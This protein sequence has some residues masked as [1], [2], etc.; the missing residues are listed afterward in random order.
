MP[1]QSVSSARRDLAKSLSAF[2]S[3]DEASAESWRWFDEGLGWNKARIIAYGDEPIDEQAKSQIEAWCNRR[4]TGEPWAYILGRAIWRGRP[5]R[6]TPATL[7]P[8]PDTELAF[9]A[10]LRLAGQLGVKRV[11]DVGTGCGILAITLA[12]EAPHLYVAA[13]DISM[14]A[15][16]AASQNAADHSVHIEWACGHILEPLSDPIDMV[17]SNLPYICPEGESGLQRE[18][19]FEP[20]EALFAAD[21]GMGA[22]TELLKQ[23]AERQ[24]KG[25]VAEIGSGQGGELLSRTL[26]FGWKTAET[27]QD[28]AGHDR[29]LI[30][31]L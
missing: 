3:K 1:S 23:G 24:V 14:D 31:M 27:K 8:R 22:I 29:V 11:V 10:A 13:T 16:A 15:L 9:E 25:L 17:V 20:R 28:M 7:I 5:F 4:E 2:L 19:S 18:L 6:V 21:G 26:G 30:A 12:I